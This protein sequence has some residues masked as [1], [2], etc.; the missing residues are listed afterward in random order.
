MYPDLLWFSLC[1]KLYDFVHY[2]QCSSIVDPLYSVSF[3]SLKYSP[4]N[5]FSNISLNQ[6]FV[7]STSP[8]PWNLQSFAPLPP[9]SFRISL[10]F[11]LHLSLAGPLFDE[12]LVSLQANRYVYL[13]GSVIYFRIPITQ[14]PFAKIIKLV[15]FFLCFLFIHPFCSLFVVP[16][17]NW[18]SYVHASSSRLI[19]SY[20]Y[21][22]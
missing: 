11:I 4:H 2:F 7:R 20:R 21:A 14:R 5:R 1:G 6:L 16:K 15:G 9:V 8:S 22:C 18:H 13:L 19:S 3:S 17:K 12:A 10:G